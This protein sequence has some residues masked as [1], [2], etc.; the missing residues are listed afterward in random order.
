MT[1]IAINNREKK[2]R[3]VGRFKRIPIFDL[4][5]A[6]DVARFVSVNGAGKLDVYS[7]AEVMGYSNTTIRHHINSAKHHNIITSSNDTVDLTAIGRAIV[8]PMSEE[9]S[10]DCKIKAFL[11]C[12]LYNRIYFKYIGQNLPKSEILGNIF[13]RDEGVSFKTKDR[14]AQN[15]I[16]SG[17]LVGLIDDNDGTYH[18]VE[19]INKEN[20]IKEDEF[21]ESSKTK[22]MEINAITESAK[23]EVKSTQSSDKIKIS[24]EPFFELYIKSDEAAFEALIQLLPH[25]KKIYCKTDDDSL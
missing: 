15:F 11:A 16:K 12:D 21:D 14:T 9:E 13:A 2:I 18:C 23:T 1:E 25:Y 22:V 5:D 17:V 4:K 8:N 6:I 7:L 3:Q 19:A 24:T 10:K 20:I